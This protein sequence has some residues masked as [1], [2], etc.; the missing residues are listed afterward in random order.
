MKLSIVVPVYN[1]EEYL[2][3]CLESLIDPDVDDYEIIAVNDGSTDHSG[4]ILE[5]Y[6]R[7][8]PGLVKKMDTPNGGLGHARNTGI[9]ASSGEYI[10]FVDSDDWL[11]PGAVREM[12]L[13]LQR[14]FDIAVF[15][16]TQVDE[17][18]KELAY[19]C[20]VEYDK[21]FSLKEYPEFLFSPHNAVNKLWRRC[22][23]LDNAIRFP[24]RL[25]F[26]DLAPVPKLYLHADRIVPIHRAWYCYYQRSGSIMLGADRL[27]RNL[28]MIQV[29]GEVLSYYR[30]QQ[31]FDRY[32]EQLEYK[33][34][35]EEYL[36][37]VT[38]VNQIDR[39]STVQTKLRDDYLK[40]FPAYRKNRYVRSASVRIRML[41]A[42]IRKEQWN[43]VHGMIAMNNRLKGR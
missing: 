2:D 24:D 12:L 19:C 16:F 31:M 14:D 32:R 22:L 23:F 36:A 27:N 18:G 1:T 6:A 4:S 7:Q 8:Y 29:A 35:Y 3:K 42:M 13:A 5:R 17:T 37:S 34:F 39:S 11:A 33:F 40:R 30:E 28:E 20:G 26:E 15:D 21:D 25:W 41:D 9:E 10:L 43:A 38:R